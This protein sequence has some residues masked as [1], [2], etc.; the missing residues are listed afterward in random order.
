MWQCFR[1]PSALPAADT[2]Y[3]LVQANGPLTA[4]NRKALEATGAKILEY[5]PEN[6]Y[7][8]RYAP[9]DCGQSDVRRC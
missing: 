5:V 1:A 6:A 2:N 4:A 8:C 3:V 9:A 7:V